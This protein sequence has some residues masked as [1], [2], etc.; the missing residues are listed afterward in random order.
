MKINFTLAAA[1]ACLFCTKGISRAQPAGAQAAGIDVYDGFE[2]PALSK[3]WS[4][5]RFVAGAVSMQTNFVRSGQSAA[6]I[7][8]H[9]GEKFEAG[10]NGNKDSERAELREGTKQLVSK[11]SVNYEQSFSVF[12][13]TNFPMVPVR[14][15]IAQWKQYCSDGGNCS[16]D[17]P[18][19]AIRY[20]SGTLKITQNIHSNH[21][22]VLYQEKAEFRGR[23]L[24]F[25]F[26]VRFTP[27]ENGQIKA[28]LDGKQVVDY[29]GVTANPEN[30]VT[31]YPSPSY[32]Y[33]K[34]GLYRDVMPEPMTIYIDEYR[35]KQ[36]SDGEI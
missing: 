25:K 33:F 28:W 34:M 7:T 16:D 36:L 29:R 23:W 12:F 31:G 1:I 20:I 17:S 30:A 11:E 8:V 14:L 10:I 22:M 32:F 24:N 15:V 18:V 9:A 35:K 5:D 2:T 4:T 21:E 3:L 6:Q 13:P 19:L 26:Q 27:E